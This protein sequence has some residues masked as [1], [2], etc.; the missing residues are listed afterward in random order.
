MKV[1]DLKNNW[2]ELRADLIKRLPHLRYVID[3]C[4]VQISETEV[5]FFF[6]KEHKMLKNIAEH[7]Q[8]DIKAELD[9][10]TELDVKVGIGVLV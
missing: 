10:M 9:K 4:E 7:Y 5:S 2:I 3:N 8:Y 1:E 6:K